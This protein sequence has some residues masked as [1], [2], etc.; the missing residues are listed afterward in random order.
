MA[1]Y[2]QFLTYCV[3][4]TVHLLSRTSGQDGRSIDAD[5][6]DNYFQTSA[7]WAAPTYGRSW[8]GWKSAASDL[9]Q[10]IKSVTDQDV[11]LSKDFLHDSYQSALDKANAQVDSSTFA[12]SAAGSSG[13]QGA[14]FALA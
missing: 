10:Q 9:T 8:S 12:R 3:L 5:G 1:G 7:F 11:D 14:A 4:I 2:K 13:A 6:A